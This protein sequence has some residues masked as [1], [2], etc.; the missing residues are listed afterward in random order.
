[1]IPFQDF[2]RHKIKLFL[3]ENYIDM[4]EEYLNEAAEIIYDD[5]ILGKTL[6]Q[7]IHEC[8]VSALS[9]YILLT[10]D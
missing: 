2:M 7:D 8:I 1:M 10:K 9:E 5:Y 3:F 4:C 6:T